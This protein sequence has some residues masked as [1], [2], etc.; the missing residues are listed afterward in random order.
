MSLEPRSTT[1]L[2]EEV[3]LKAKMNPVSLRKAEIQDDQLSKQSLN[4]SFK[5]RKM[6]QY[7]VK[8]ILGSTKLATKVE[9]FNL[10]TEQRSLERATSRDYKDN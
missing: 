9:P 10:M 4:S 8:P 6:P 1:R 2:I 5:A 7:Q 3:P